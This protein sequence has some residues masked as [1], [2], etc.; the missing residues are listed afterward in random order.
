M[1]SP[2][3]FVDPTGHWFA[4]PNL[5]DGDHLRHTPPKPEKI[6]PEPEPEPEDESEYIPQGSGYE[7][8]EENNWAYY[9]YGY[10]DKEATKSANI[11]SSGCGIVSLVMILR[12][13]GISYGSISDDI[14]Y[15]KEYMLNNG[16]RLLGRGTSKQGMANY[17]RELGLNVSFTSD[18][19]EVASSLHNGSMAIAH[20]SSQR[21]EVFTAGSGHYM[22]LDSISSNDIVHVHNPNKIGAAAH[23]SGTSDYS[24]PQIVNNLKYDP[25]TGKSSTFMIFS[26]P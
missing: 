14:Y 17:A 12:S 19:D 11:W 8:Y 20:V 25:E 18:P 16:H 2:V 10:K 21:S 9:D 15:A 4:H 1:T 22:T 24:I 3:N 5:I 6:V 13:F 26:R 7:G 23:Y